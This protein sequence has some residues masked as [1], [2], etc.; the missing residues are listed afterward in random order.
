MSTVL[1]ERIWIFVYQTRVEAN[2]VLG[3]DVHLGD[4]IFVNGA[5]VLPHKSLKENILNPGTIVI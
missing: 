1:T 3:M 2:T 4:E 5:N